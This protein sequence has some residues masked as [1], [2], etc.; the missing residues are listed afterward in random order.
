[1]KLAAVDLGTNTCLLLVAEIAPDGTVVTLQG[2]QRLPRLGSSVDATG[3]M[4]PAAQERVAAV[5]REYVQIARSHGI[6]TL[7]VCATSALRDAKNSHEF[8]QQIKAAL[9][10]EI[11]VLSGDEEAMWTYRGALC[12]LPDREQDRLVIDIGGGSTELSHPVPGTRNGSTRLTRYSL[13][14][15]AVRLT[16]R[17]LKHSPPS[18]AEIGSARTFLIEELAQVHN[19]GFSRYAVVAVAGTATTLACLDQGLPAFDAA[20][21]SGYR[22]SFAAVATWCDRL[23]RMSAQEIAALSGATEGRADILGAGALI[24]REIMDL[25]RIDAVEVSEKGLRYGIALREWSRRG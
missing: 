10:V 11:E 9:G 16:E 1:M 15:G 20:R 22:L 12:G 6:D 18:P 23:C 4:H 7:T 25:Y 14:L 13:Q 2:E 21:V 8:R 19:P 17:H 24:L 5:L 3:M